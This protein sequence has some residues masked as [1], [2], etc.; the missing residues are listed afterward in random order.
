MLKANML[1]LMMI[2]DNSSR[3]CLL[4]REH[5]QPIGSKMQLPQ[6]TSQRGT[7]SKAAVPCRLCGIRA[8]A[9]KQGPS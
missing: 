1:V 2:S 4:C 9:S 7:R 5:R 3:S 8:S 6:W